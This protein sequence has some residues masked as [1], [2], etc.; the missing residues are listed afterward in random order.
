M[1]LNPITSWHK[2]IQ[3]TAPLP[4]GAVPLAGETAGLVCLMPTGRWIMWL[5][6]VMSSKPPETQREVMEVII[7]Q[8]GGTAAATAEALDVSRRTVEAWRTGAAKLPI[9]AAYQIAEKLAE[10]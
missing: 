2:W 10:L 3:G 6:G 4:A 8:L 9:K 7:S 1:K 5:G